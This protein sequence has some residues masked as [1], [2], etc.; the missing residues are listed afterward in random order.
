MVYTA[1][2]GIVATGSIS[3]HFFIDLLVDPTT[4]GVID[5][6][7]KPVA[8]ASRSVAK[9]EKFI[10]DFGNGVQGVKAYGSYADLFA[11]PDVDVV[12]IGTP[13]SSHYE[14]SLQA[15]KAGKH[16]LCEKAFTINA[17][18]ARHLADYA[19]SHNLF[20]MEAVW[21]R[22]FPLALEFQKLLHEDKVIGAIR[23]VTTD[24]AHKFVP[25]VDSRLYNPLLG[26]GALLDVGVYAMTWIQM[27]CYQHP[28]NKKSRPS[29]INSTVLKTPLTGVDESTVITMVWDKPHIISTATCSIAVNSPEECL[30]R[31]QGDLGEIVVPISTARP[32]EFIVKINATAEGELDD[33]QTH[34]F[35]IPGPT[36]LFWEAD[37]VARDIRDGKIVDDIYPVEESV[38]V[39][40]VFD[41]VRRQNDFVYPAAIEFVEKE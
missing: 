27:I 15:L 3:E 39:M 16:V 28:D 12:Y 9:A 32:T 11:D 20:L 2:W 13:H 21:T 23:R 1:R 38:F 33:V 34:K 31:V 36:G 22:F 30:V 8:V 14:V 4:R 41:E 35:P 26:G 24:L 18:Q 25:D 5:V 40:E 19:K 37:A 7:H 6:V 29:I 10:S 17:A